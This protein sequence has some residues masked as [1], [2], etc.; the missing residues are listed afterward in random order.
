MLRHLVSRMSLFAKSVST[1]VGTALAALLLL[2]LSMPAAHAHATLLV[3]EPPDG[4]VLPRAPPLLRL[5]FD[6]PVS[7]LVLRLVG[8]G[9]PAI[10]LTAV[11]QQGASLLITPPRI[12]EGTHALSWRVISA[13]GHP[14]G[15][16]VVFSVGAPSERPALSPA[17]DPQVAGALWVAKLVLYAGML[18]G[19]GGAFFR[20]WFARGAPAAQV[21]IVAMLIAGLIATPVTLGLQGL[22]ALELSLSGLAARASWLAGLSTAY[23]ATA[24]VA[25]FALFAGLF[26]IAAQSAGIARLLSL[27]GLL[28]CGVA[29]TLSGHASTADPQALTRPAVVIHAA[30]AAFWA[31]ALLPLAASLRARDVAPL[32]RFTRAIPWVVAPLAAAGLVLA[33]VQVDSIASLWTTAYGRVLCAK[34]AAVA[35]LLALAALNRTILTGRVVA[36][37]E[38]ARR[39]LRCAIAAEVV[40]MAAIL[41]LVAAW[42][43]TPPP[44]ALALARAAPALVHIHTEALMADLKLTP[45]RTG[46]VVATVVVMRGD[47]TPFVPKD[48]TLVLSQGAAGIEPIRR[49]AV[50]HDDVWRAELTLPAPGRWQ[51]RIDVLVSDF[52][53]VML[54]DAI[55]IAP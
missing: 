25:A 8:A 26:S 32:R 11:S 18:A 15:G 37:D 51:V 38:P 10:P 5:T 4:A 12:G 43:F 53:K 22:D 3:A 45:G 27:A 47:F 16:T 35:A 49:A 33:L 7:P 36:G 50:L 28:G 46:P 2:A 39:H 29:L 23:G 31:G 41:G 42:R 20:A 34:L 14:V 19:I 6:E 24:I 52:E 40:L 9:G 1:F 13:D 30:G 55:E 17:G 21:T 54:E 48:V 44:R